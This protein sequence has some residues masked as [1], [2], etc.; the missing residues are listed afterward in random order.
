MAVRCRLVCVSATMHCA[1]GVHVVDWRT[2]PVQNSL[3]YLAAQGCLEKVDYS[4]VIH[5]KYR[6]MYDLICNI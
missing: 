1:R 6:P 3:T 4:F 5:K 2:A